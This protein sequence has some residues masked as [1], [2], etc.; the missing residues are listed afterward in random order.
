MI[1]MTLEGLVEAI[2]TSGQHS[3]I[4]H[5]TDE[6]NFPTIETHG[7]LSK[8][9]MARLGIAAQAPGGNSWSWEADRIKGISDY[10]SLCMTRNHPMCHTATKEE[11]ITKPR[12]L[13]IKPDILLNEGVLFAFDI[14]NKSG[15]EVMPIRD[16]LP[17]I[18]YHVI[19]TRTDW[20][21][22]EVQARLTAAER[23][24][25]LV[26]KHIPVNKIARTY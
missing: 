12:Y 16:A 13:C 5:F 7:L 25:V 15:I 22:S 3:Y 20:R 2:K 24:E 18:D 21:N 19:Y 1:G 9:E 11:R 26:P 14:A 4:Y 23:C 8:S 10:I 6:S 17:L